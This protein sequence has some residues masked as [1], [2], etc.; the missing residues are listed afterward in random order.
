[1]QIFIGVLATLG[2]MLGAVFLWALIM[3][4]IEDRQEKAAAK[5]GGSVDVDVDAD[6]ENLERTFVA[7]MGGVPWNVAEQKTVDL[8]WD[9]AGRQ[10]T[11]AVVGSRILEIERRGEDKGRRQMIDYIEERAA[12][13]ENVYATE[14]ILAVVASIRTAYGFER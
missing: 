3:T 14:E 4:L 10:R 7:Y 2:V 8:L 12:A 6:A 11:V 1:M 5:V 13:V 9:A